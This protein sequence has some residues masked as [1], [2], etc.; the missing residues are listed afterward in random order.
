[1]NFL[2]DIAWEGNSLVLYE[3]IQ[4]DNCSHGTLQRYLKTILKNPITAG[5]KVR[6]MEHSNSLF[7]NYNSSI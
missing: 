6:I 4:P 5:F 1:M 2:K 7:I 3:S